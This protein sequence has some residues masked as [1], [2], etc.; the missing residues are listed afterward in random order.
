MVRYR[1]QL[2]RL[3]LRGVGGKDFIKNDQSAVPIA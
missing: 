1:L 3:L 2:K